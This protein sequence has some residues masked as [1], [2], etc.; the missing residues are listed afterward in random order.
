[1][2]A[3]NGTLAYVPGL[4]TGIQGAI[5]TLSW[6]D[7]HGREEPVA[8]PPR[9][10]AWARL[11]PDETQIALD[12]RDQANDVWTFDVTRQRLTRITTVPATES[13]PIWTR[14][15]RALLFESNRVGGIFNVFRQ[16]SDGAGSA[17]QLTN[18]KNPP[19]SNTSATQIVV[20]V[21]WLDEL[22]SKLS[23]R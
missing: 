13:F 19:A 10:N 3:G 14:D 9:T 20:V 22:R 4:D 8:V 15:G 23:A 17:E 21:N 11:S 16:S 1:M 6:Y 7:R 2:L 18:S 5:R 12:I